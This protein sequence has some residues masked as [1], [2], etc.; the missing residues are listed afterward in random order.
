MTNDQLA[1]DRATCHAR[2]HLQ[3]CDPAH[4]NPENNYCARC[5]E[6]TSRDR[7]SFGSQARTRWPAALDEIDRLKAENERLRQ[8]RDSWKAAAEAL[9]LWSESLADAEMADVVFLGVTASVE[10]LLQTARGGRHVTKPT[11]QEL[12]L[13]D[14]LEHFKDL[15]QAWKKAAH[16]ESDYR[17]AAINSEPYTEDARQVRLR[18]WVAAKDLEK[19]DTEQPET[20]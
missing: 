7:A 12:H 10:A 11:P 14:R 20:D 6:K 16:A 4:V 19:L 5:R 13:Y 2:E 18:A 17:V 8:H 3:P 15:A 9:D 1:A